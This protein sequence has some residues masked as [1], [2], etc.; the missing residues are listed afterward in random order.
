MKSTLDSKF[1][2]NVAKA[3]PMPEAPAK[4]PRGSADRP[5][6]TMR[7]S[8]ADWLLMREFADGQNKSLNAL[9]IEGFQA[10]Q[11]A[12]KVPPISGK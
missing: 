6:I 4:A 8:R 5:A 7:V 2:S 9:L 11:R 12:A 1:A 3:E 10:L